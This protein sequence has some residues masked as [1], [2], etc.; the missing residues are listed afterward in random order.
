MRKILI[1][2]VAICSLVC[3]TGCLSSVDTQPRFKMYPTDNMF[4]FL[5]LDSATGQIWMVQ[6]AMGER[7]GV[8]VPLDA[9]SLLTSGESKVSGRYELYPTENMFTF[10]MLD[11]QGGSTYQVQWNI[12]EDKRFRIPLN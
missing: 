2:I 11:T 3:T 7:E 9:S 1:L 12:E 4:I 8:V 5:K 10:I 6:Y